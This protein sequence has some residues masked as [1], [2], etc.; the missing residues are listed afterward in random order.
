MATIFD[1][2][3]VSELVLKWQKTKDT[4]AKA[5]LWA[6]IVAECKNCLLAIIRTYK[7]PLADVGTHDEILSEL[8]LRLHKLLNY[9]NPGRGRFYSFLVR[10]CLNYLSTLR[11]KA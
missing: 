6:Q 3:R 8:V 9:F 10:C 1:E 2:A 11:D 5:E 7:W 4:E